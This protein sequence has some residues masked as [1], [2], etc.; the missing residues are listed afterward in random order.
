LREGQPCQCTV[1]KSFCT[2]CGNPLGE[3]QACICTSHVEPVP[4]QDAISTDAS[5]EISFT[6]SAI[7]PEPAP[8]RLQPPPPIPG[9]SK[10]VERPTIVKSVKDMGK[11]AISD[12]GT[13]DGTT[14]LVSDYVS[15]I[16]GEVSVKRYHVAT[17]R[18]F[19]RFTHAAGHLEIT[20]RRI[21]FRAEKR[22]FG[23]KTI[24]QREHNIEEIAGLEAVSNHRFSFARLTVGFFTIII[25]A[26]LAAWGV[27]ALTHGRLMEE[28]HIG[29]MMSRPSLTMVLPWA[30]DGLLEGWPPD[31]A[32][33]SMIGG[34]IAGF[35]G[36]A[37]FFLIRG[38]VWPKQVLLGISVGGFGAVALTYN[39]Y[40]SILLVLSMFI[41]VFGLVLFSW[42]PDLVI[43]VR[44]K[45][46]VVV[47]IVRGRRFTD[48]LHGSAGAGY[49]EVA[50][51]VETEA[52]IRELGAVISDIQ[53]LGDDGVDMWRDE[54]WRGP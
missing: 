10:Y 31:I 16:S 25:F 51:N 53:R 26:A 14:Q 35:G 44:S 41:A 7:K 23:R 50:P 42:L 19:L 5:P 28:A 12:T 43:S 15:P 21:I 3:G 24:I 36:I 22:S 38:K 20:N 29:T 4:L 18:S 13:Y 11:A 39:L 40:A 47:P 33:I 32:S 46:G 1:V 54:V 45:E 6:D 52:V 17:L 30:L 48:A 49:A 2:Q 8:E 27:I 37:L 34:L 9:R